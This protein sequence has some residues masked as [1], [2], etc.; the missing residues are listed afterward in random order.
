MHP[1]KQPRDQENS[2]PVR[3]IFYWLFMHLGFDTWT[4]TLMVWFLFLPLL[5]SHHCEPTV[6]VISH[7]L[8]VLASPFYHYHKVHATTEEI[9]ETGTGHSP[10]RDAS[11]PCLQWQRQWQRWPDVTTGVPQFWHTPGIWLYPLLAERFSWVPPAMKHPGYHF[12]WGAL[13][14]IQLIPHRYPL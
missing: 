5:V 11:P 12:R 7:N 4:L 14:P 2:I 8:C 10:Q 6:S 9:K 1:Q 13:K 3:D